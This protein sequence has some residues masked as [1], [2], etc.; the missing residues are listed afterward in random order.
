[1]LNELEQHKQASNKMNNMSKTINISQMV[2]INKISITTMINN[3]NKSN[4]STTK[5]VE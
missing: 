1:M 2:K 5:L 3:Q 4:I